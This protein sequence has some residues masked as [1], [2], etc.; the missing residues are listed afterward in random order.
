MQ[1]LLGRQFDSIKPKPKGSGL[2]KRPVKKLAD[3]VYDQLTEDYPKKAVDWVHNVKWAGP[4]KV[5]LKNVDFEEKNTWKAEKEPD[6]VSLF[7]NRIRAAAR[8]HEGIKPVVMIARPDKTVMVMDGH[9]RALAYRELK[10]P[11][12]AWVGYP[13]KSKGPWDK[14]HDYQFKPGTGPQREGDK[15]ENVYR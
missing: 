6:K 1:H 2:P 10:K 9:H 4:E 8:K 14:V 7:K 12:Y 5:P 13:G 11:V 3:A 15:R